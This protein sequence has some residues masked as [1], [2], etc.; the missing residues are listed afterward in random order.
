L[1]FSRFF[2]ALVEESGWS[3]DEYEAWLLETLKE[4]LL[5]RAALYP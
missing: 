5:P 4:Q 3:P 2:P 1:P